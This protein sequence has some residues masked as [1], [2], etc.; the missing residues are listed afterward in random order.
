MRVRFFK[1]LG[2]DGQY[3]VRANGD[4]IGDVHKVYRGRTIAGWT[5]HPEGYVQRTTLRVGYA[6]R[7]EAAEALIAYCRTGKASLVE[8]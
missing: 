4:Y 2:T 1:F 3:A 5:V 7:R 6:T 8:G